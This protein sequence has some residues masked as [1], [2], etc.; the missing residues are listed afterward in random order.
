MPKTD[1]NDQK[2]TDY[3]ASLS[4]FAPVIDERAHT[5][6]LGSFP[7]VASLKSQQYYGFRHNQFWRLMSDVIEEDLMVLEYRHKLDALLSAG[8]GLWDVFKS[9]QRQGSLD[10][11]IREGQFNDFVALRNQYPRLQRV[12]FNGKTAAK[13]QAY[14]DDHGYSTLVLPSSSPANAM[15]TFE[16][17]LLVWRK[18]RQESE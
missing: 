8:I 14:F 16:Q 4:G 12:C 13:I 7:G 10:S 1:K 3:D 2:Y 17:K 18:I 5:L 9:C 6:V 15:Q 11:A